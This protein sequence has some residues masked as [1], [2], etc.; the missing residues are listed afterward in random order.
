MEKFFGRDSNSGFFAALAGLLAPNGA[1][2]GFF[3][4]PFFT[5]GWS[6]RRGHQSL[7]TVWTVDNAWLPG[8]LMLCAPRCIRAQQDASLPSGSEK[9]ENH[10][11]RA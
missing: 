4:V 9:T 3:P 8:A 7:V 10:L 1:E 11:A 6:L 5:G 2:A